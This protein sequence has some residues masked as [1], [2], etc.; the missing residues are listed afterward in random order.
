M[1]AVLVYFKEIQKAEKHMESR[2]E[3]IET[4]LLRFVSTVEQELA[5]SRDVLSILEGFK[6]NTAPAFA[7]ELGITCA[8][9]RSG[10]YEVALMRMEARVNSPQLSDVV[11]GLISVIRGDNGKM[12]FQ[13]LSHDFKQMELRK[14]KAKAQ[15]I[16]G[17]N[18]C[19]LDNY[20]DVLFGDISDSYSLS[21]YSVDRSYVL[22]GEDGE[23][24]R[25]IL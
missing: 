5:S 19:V 18:P 13:M 15:K 12:Y 17:K 4:E 20:A 22:G 23:Q 16:P 3:E 25:N 10:G 2:R 11:R 21:D 7:D 24:R 8:D 6:K 1:L 9:M 14:L